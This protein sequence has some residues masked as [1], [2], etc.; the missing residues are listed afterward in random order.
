MTEIILGLLAVLLQGFFAG[1]ET[2]IAR[3]N[4]I[5]LTTWKK[6]TP[7]RSVFRFRT[8]LPLIL[9]EHKETMLIVTLI[10]TNIFIVL[11]STI[12]SRFFIIRFGAAYV[13]IAVIIVVTLSMVLGDFIPKIIAQSF[14]EYWL[15]VSSPLLRL[16]LITFKPILPRTNTEYYNRLSRR[17]FLLLLK[18]NKISEMKKANIRLLTH[19]IA[20]ALFDFSK[21]VITDIMIPKERIVAFSDDISLSQIKKIVA[22][23][24]FSRYPIYQKNIDNIVAIVHIKDILMASQKRYF[25][26]NKIY[27]KP[28][29]I[30]SNEKAVN[31]LKTMR[32]SGEHLGIIKNEQNQTIG[33]ITLE[34]LL[35][36]LIGEIR[37]E[38]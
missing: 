31:V 1:S 17:D 5:Q 11:A 25:K 38:A 6:Q 20:K 8:D 4:W 14:P 16:L 21:L 29:F 18:D 12:F 7:F 30:A 23:Y 24:R 27:R 36:E 2:A 37:S 19:Q 33:M 22:K 34:D 3:A 35:E 28:Y 32:R 9:I 15:M 13:T 10:F 26:L